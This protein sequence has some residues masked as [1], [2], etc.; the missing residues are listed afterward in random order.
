MELMTRTNNGWLPNLLED[1]FDDRLTENGFNTMKSLP[2]VNIEEKEDKFSLELA[3]P[4]KTK[5]DF[6]IELDNDLLT[7]SSEI[8]EEHKSEDKDRNFTRREFSYESFKRSFTLPDSVDTN[9]VKANY[10]NGVLTVDL[11]KRDEAKKQPKRLI[12][13]S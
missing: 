1:I 12:D 13:I 5:K 2:A 6:N 8:K 10:K 4:G 11:P 3:A 9:K 7:I